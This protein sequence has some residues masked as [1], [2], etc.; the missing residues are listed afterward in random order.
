MTHYENPTL[1]VKIQIS[2]KKRQERE[3]PLRP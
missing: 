2:L 3:M 1:R